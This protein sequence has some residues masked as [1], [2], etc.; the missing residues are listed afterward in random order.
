MGLNYIISAFRVQIEKA[1]TSSLI[2]NENLAFIPPTTGMWYEE[3]CIPDDKPIT[4]GIGKD[5]NIRYM[6][7]YQI[8][9]HT[10]KGIGK[11]YAISEAERIRPYF[12]PQASLVY[13][14][15]AKTTVLVTGDTQSVISSPYITILIKSFGYSKG[16][17]GELEG[18]YVL[19]VRIVWMAT[20]PS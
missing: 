10:K 17:V 4:D 1:I 5:A 14:Y 6:G 12:K 13:S 8:N 20:I 18:E 3:Y 11:G 16:Y 2:A 15:T 9:I 7:F 19:P